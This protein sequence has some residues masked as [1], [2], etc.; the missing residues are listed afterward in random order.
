MSQ[1]K[2]MVVEDD[3]VIFDWKKKC[4][5]CGRKKT[6]KSDI[7]IFYGYESYLDG[8]ALTVTVCPECREKHTI[9]EIYSKIIKNLIEEVKN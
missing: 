9:A 3:D 1:E 7:Q 8:T 2:K 4:L 5:F 6:W